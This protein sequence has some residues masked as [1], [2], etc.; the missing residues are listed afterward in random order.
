MVLLFSSRASECSFILTGWGFR[1]NKQ[2]EAERKVKGEVV[3]E[4]T[5]L[6]GAKREVKHIYEKDRKAG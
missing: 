5:K 6:R 4:E 1:G 3:V 2:R